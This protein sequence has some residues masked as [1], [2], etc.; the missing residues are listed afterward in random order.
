VAY[1]RQQEIES[2]ERI[3]VG[4]N[5]FEVDEDPAMDLE[6]VDEADEAWQVDRLEQVKAERDEAAVESA[7]AAV[8]DAAA[9]GE[10]VFP[11]VIEAV[12]AYATVQEI[13]DVFREEFGEYQ[14]GI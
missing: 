7:L 9:G 11:P 4:V 6:T 1:E 8:A 13:C 2:G 10:N 12:K 5:E 14:P 3:I